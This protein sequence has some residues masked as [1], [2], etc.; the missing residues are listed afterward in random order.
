MPP[1]PLCQ[2]TTSKVDVGGMAVEVEP[3]HQY[4]ITCCYRVT[5]G[6]WGA[7]WQHGGWHR[8]V[9]EAKVCHWIPPYRK[10]CTLW[11]SLET[12]ETMNNSMKDRSCSRWP[13]R[14]LEAQHAGFFFWWKY[15]ANGGDY[16]EKRCFV[17]ENLLCQTV[18]SCRLYLLWK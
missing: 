17:A 3:S 5:D 18:L 10:N 1:L 11:H 16:I 9:Y 2:P 6:S 12:L 7:V 15:I 4:S 14:F 8:S 13:C